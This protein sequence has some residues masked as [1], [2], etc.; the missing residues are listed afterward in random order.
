MLGENITSPVTP[1]SSQFP[2]SRKYL[3]F[4]MK[5]SHYVDLAVLEVTMYTR[6]TPHRDSPASASVCWEKKTVAPC[7]SKIFVFLYDN[8]YQLL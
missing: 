1:L 4:F 7:L 5:G 3:P 6:L 8:D 2:Y